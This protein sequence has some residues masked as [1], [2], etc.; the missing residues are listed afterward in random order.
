MFNININIPA[1]ALLFGEYGLLNQGVGVCC[2]LPNIN[3]EVEI[4]ITN[5]DISK[6]I[7]DSRFFEGGKEEFSFS[8]SNNNSF[9]YNAILPWKEHLLDKFL[10]IKVKKSFSPSLGFGSS[11]SMITAISYGLISYITQKIP[12]LTDAYLWK[13]IRQS[14]QNTQKTASGY[15]VGIQIAY[16]LSTQTSLLWNTKDLFW[17]FQNTNTEVPILQKLS[18]EDDLIAKMGSF[19]KTHTYSNTTLVMKS[20]S[21]LPQEDRV[22]YAEK[23][24]KIAQKFLNSPTLI[25]LLEC[26]HAAQKLSYEQGILIDND[27]SRNL[28]AH[29]VAFK[30]MGSGYGDCL[31]VFEHPKKL[32]QSNIVSQDDIAFSFSEL[33]H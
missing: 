23:H 17:T 29:E 4:T 1:K 33:G 2:V 11:A 18:L 22:M 12:S 9:F 13:N 32:L 31:W 7:I 3:F 24:T 6:V 27:L 19:I 5:S 25:T 26:M 28:K 15:D 14:L 16:I 8:N 20:F 30:T 21:S 10:H